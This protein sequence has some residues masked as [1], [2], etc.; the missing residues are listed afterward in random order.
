MHVQSLVYVCL[1]LSV[2]VLVEALDLRVR[3]G[4]PVGS[5]VGLVGD[6]EQRS[7]GFLLSDQG[8][9]GLKDFRFD[10]KSGELYTARVLDHESQDRYTFV[11]VSSATVIPVSV[12]VLDVNDNAPVF[13]ATTVHFLV[14]EQAPVGTRFPLEPADD[15]DSDLLDVQGYVLRSGDLTD[16]FVLETWRAGGGKLLV[17]LALQ[18]AL[19]RETVSEYSLLLEAF[20]GGDPPRSGVLMVHV[21]VLDENDNPPVFSKSYYEAS[22]SE[23]TAPGVRVLPVVATDR[24]AGRNAA[25]SYSISRRWSDPHPFFSID[26]HSGLVRLHRPVDFELQTMHEFIVEA[27]DNGSE[28]EVGT[29]IVTVSVTDFN[30]NAPEIRVIWLTKNGEPKIR[31]NV[32]LGT[33]VARISVTDRDSGN[34]SLVSVSLKGDEQKFWL[35]SQD[36]MVYLL[37]VNSSLDHEEKHQYQLE[38]LARDHGEPVLQTTTV[39]HLVVL[40]END[41][42]PV[43]DKPWIELA[44]S[45][46]TLPGTP[47]LTVRATDRDSGRNGALLYTLNSKTN[48]KP[49]SFNIDSVSGVISTV[50]QLVPDGHLHQ[51]TVVATDY[52]DP[53]LSGSSVVTITVH[54]KLTKRPVFQHRVYNVSIKQDVPPGT[55]FL[56]VNAQDED[57]GSMGS[58]LYTLS[59]HG[60]LGYVPE[61][62][63]D[64]QTGRLCTRRW[65]DL[66]DGPAKRHFLVFA[67]DGGG[68]Q[69]HAKVHIDLEHTDSNQLRFHDT[70]FQARLGLPAP[71]GAAVVR[72]TAA[73]YP[74]LGSHGAPQYHIDKGNSDGLFAIDTNTGLITLARALAVSPVASR[75]Q[76]LSVLAQVGES[77]EATATANV[78]VIFFPR[79]SASSRPR[80]HPATWIPEGKQDGSLTASSLPVNPPRGASD[81]NISEDAADWL[82][83]TVDLSR[84]G[85]AKGASGITFVMP[86]PSSDIPRSLHFLRDPELVS[87]PEGVPIGT[88]LRV[89]LA[90]GN[91]R[92]TPNA[93][94]RYEVIGQVP[95]EPPSFTMDPDTGTLRTKALLDR[96][97]T[98]KFLVVVKATV[99]GDGGGVAKSRT[100]ETTVSVVISVDDKNDNKPEFLPHGQISVS[101]GAPAGWLLARLAATDADIGD[102]ATIHYALVSG[103]EEGTFDLDPDTGQL[104]LSGVLDRESN[105]AYDLVVEARDGGPFALISRITLSITILDVNEPPHVPRGS[106]SGTVSENQPPGQRV[107]QLLATDTDLG[108]N[109]ELRYS[110]PGGSGHGCFAV[111]PLS[112]ELRTTRPLDREEQP[113]FNVTVLVTDGG[114]PPLSAVVLVGVTVTDE[115]DNIPEFHMDLSETDLQI[116]ENVPPTPLLSLIAWDRDSGSNGH[117][118]YRITG[119]DTPGDFFLHPETGVLS[120]ARP[121]DREAISSYTLHVEAMDGGS[122]PLS[123]T[124][125]LNVNVLDQN[126]H[127]PIFPQT[128]YATS[129]AEDAEP[130]VVVVSAQARDV[131]QGPGGQLLYW[132]EGDVGGDFAVGVRDGQ[133]CTR[134]AL[135][136]ERRSS[137]T[138]WLMVSDIGPQRVLSSS[139]RVTIS[140]TDVNDNAP[141]FIENPIVLKTSRFTQPGL[142]LTTLRAHDPDFGPNASMLYRFQQLQPDSQ[143]LF[144]L[145]PRSGEVRAGPGLVGISTSPVVIGVEAAD[146]GWPSHTT[147][148]LLIL[149]IKESSPPPLRFEQPVIRTSVSGGV[150]SG[151]FVTRVKAKHRRKSETPAFSI[152]SGNEDRAF[153]IDAQTGEVLVLNAKALDP[154]RVEQRYLVLSAQ[155]G[156]A[157]AYSG[158]EVT[159]KGGTG[160]P[161]WFQH[162]TYIAFAEEQK[163][164]DFV[165]Q[166]W[167]LEP[168]EGPVG[169]LRFILRPGALASIFSVDPRGRIRTLNSLDH[170]VQPVYSFEVVAINHG[171]PSLSATAT[172]SVFVVDVDDN[173]PTLPPLAPIILP[174]DSSVGMLVT[175][176]SATDV[177]LGPPLI[178]SLGMAGIRKKT[179]DIAITDGTIF[180]TSP[181]DFESQHQFHVLVTAKDS[182]HVTSHNMSI[183]ITDVNDNQPSFAQPAYE[184]TLSEESSSHAVVL[185]VSAT[186]EDLGENGQL[187]YSLSSSTTNGNNFYVHPDNGTL[188]VE[189]APTY[190]ASAPQVQLMLTAHD[191]G[192]PSFSTSV[193]ILVN[194][195]PGSK[196][197]VPQCVGRKE[198]TVHVPEDTPIGVSLLDV[199][200]ITIGAD[201][202]QWDL[203]FG[204]LGAPKDLFHVEIKDIV[205]MTHEEIDVIRG[206]SFI[207]RLILVGGLDFESHSTYNFQIVVSD[208]LSRCSMSTVSVF[209]TVMDTN[210][211]PPEFLKSKYQAKIDVGSPSGTEITR[212]MAHDADSQS[213]ITYTIISGNNGG[214]FVVDHLT[215]V[216]RLEHSLKE[217][218]EHVITIS[219]TDGPHWALTTLHVSVAGSVD[220]RSLIQPV[221]KMTASVRENAPPDTPVIVLRATSSHSDDKSPLSYHIVAKRGSEQS[222]MNGPEMFSVDTFTGEVRTVRSLDQEETPALRFL[223][224]ARDINGGKTTATVIVKVEGEDEFPPV[225]SQSS[226]QFSVPTD[227]PAGFELGRVSASDA[228]AGPQGEV[229]YLLHQQSPFFS[230]DEASGAISLS[231]AAGSKKESGKPNQETKNIFL[232]IEAR[233]PLPKSLSSS[234]TTRINVSGTGLEAILTTQTA[235]SLA[236]GL[237]V[238]LGLLLLVLVTLIVILLIWR[239]KT[240]WGKH[241]TERGMITPGTGEQCNT[242]EPLLAS[243]SCPASHMDLT[244][245]PVAA[246][247]PGNVLDHSAHSHSSGRGSAEGDAAAD[248]EIRMII[249]RRSGFA[250][251]F[252]G[253]MQ[254]VLQDGCPKAL[255]IAEQRDS[256]CLSDG[257][258][259]TTRLSGLS[260]APVM[261]PVCPEDECAPCRRS[262]SIRDFIMRTLEHADTLNSPSGNTFSSIGSCSSPICKEPPVQKEMTP[263]QSTL[264]SLLDPNDDSGS[265]F[266]WDQILSWRPQFWQLAQLMAE[267]AHL[268]DES[269]PCLES[270]PPRDRFLPP[271]I[272]TSA[273]PPGARTIAPRPLPSYRVANIGALYS[274]ITMESPHVPLAMSPRLTPALSPLTTPLPPM[275]PIGVA[276]APAEGIFGCLEN[277][278]EHRGLM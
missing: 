15:A 253:A 275:S 56:Q 120:S 206:Y 113:T 272:I 86:V 238:G 162:E 79:G 169:N 32:P 3:E 233:S 21:D 130:G 220:H 259:M 231:V 254:G 177:D 184:V 44:V 183:F 135:D 36:G 66:G 92:A 9:A 156:S 77:A 49:K 265:P 7:D 43:F 98:D 125:L 20:D 17:D 64:S 218:K 242:P 60:D 148:A 4:L 105:P 202:E 75:S 160:H 180:L 16:S 256:G 28:P 249:E 82:G 54:R 167:V 172:V 271:P 274:P 38:V 25:I 74:K 5:F 208:R 13:P 250:T 149:F 181:L 39:I 127:A 95:A 230:L 267:M 119:G 42:A 100:V 104:L 112:G 26:E 70:S 31:E 114:L 53:S 111:D 134:R 235:P 23:N 62:Q 263:T 159:V 211:Q 158:L 266:D 212:V 192:S 88:A 240:G 226:Y 118:T 71:T 190:N 139:A 19:D 101:E 228:D 115:N 152:F 203:Y 109:S 189:K 65:L 93:N 255:D 129:V 219:A 34:N 225:F 10:E 154:K 27:R 173:I 258:Q 201:I 163:E 72:V 81:R 251:R 191:A 76:R 165:T 110:I 245:Y 140:I 41:N 244:H 40:D 155:A 241:N 141:Q 234:V 196:H 164:P 33:F 6:D 87:V 124:M 116:M 8:T 48:S 84:E 236:V 18:Q 126:D 178:Y 63:V 122:P 232:T 143:A 227:A 262:D 174:E 223:V 97:T 90:F 217:S 277:A 133:V 138:F 187:S 175:R 204:L 46:A 195:S 55:C 247:L 199:P 67:K 52:G 205:K 89:L 69:S 188:F 147:S 239:A 151:T 246:L 35:S 96:E 85:W 131:D 216:V 107:M 260:H 270:M 273:I 1:L 243:T 61:F 145:D 200:M 2:L 268:P 30:D 157:I 261:L 229:H 58:L 269:K 179:L 224:V 91:D 197:H 186:D 153:Q 248:D 237:T 45:E 50:R 210:D 150:S 168:D 221:H 94:A 108:R 276:L 24:D 22:L 194:L 11:A 142:I 213:L 214:L 171:A 146:Q 128:M 59:E 278:D 14:S 185:V 68:L 37:C 209:V 207:G 132:L 176:V 102:N 73:A 136:R 144:A 222:F 51:L 166:V 83:K 264:L 80:H 47:V 12:L 257:S 121:F 161:P 106:Q 252:G 78:T 193:P 198:Y 117:V 182:Q 57:S 103:N 170:E 123:S 215:G 99:V 29:S 137:Y